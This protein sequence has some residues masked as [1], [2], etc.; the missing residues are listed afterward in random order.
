MVA[1][2]AEQLD[3]GAISEWAWDAAA[4]HDPQQWQDELQKRQARKQTA[5]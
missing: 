5:A 4:G 1:E 2:T 3:D